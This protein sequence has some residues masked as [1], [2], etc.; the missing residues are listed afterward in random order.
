MPSRPA[1][2]LAVVRLSPVTITI[3][4]PSPWS[5]RIASAVDVLMGSATPMA[6]A[7]LPSTA[8][9]ITVWRCSR[10]R[11]ARSRKLSKSSASSSKAFMFPR[12]TLRPSISPATPFPVMERN[13]RGAIAAIFRSAAARIIAPASGCSLPCSILAASRRTSDSLNPGALTMAATAGFPSVRV[14]VLSTTSVSTFSI[15]SR[16][17]AFCINTPAAAPRPTATI[18]DIGVARPSAHGQ[19]MIKT[20]T[21]F[22]SA[23][24]NRG[25]GPTF[26]HTMKVII[27]ATT[28]PGT[29]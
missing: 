18:I 28:T 2:T 20:A 11:S 22:N 23:C 9:N 25:S 17:S 24:E 6:P 13:P 19:A 29:K 16:A 15:T 10:N 7:S 3:R 21:A 14:P 26:H 4:N 12:I 27:A 8:R 5:A 1:T